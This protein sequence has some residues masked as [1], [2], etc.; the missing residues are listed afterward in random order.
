MV[1][2]ERGRNTQESG[3]G[4]YLLRVV[5]SLLPLLAPGYGQMEVRT[6]Q[7]M[8]R[9]KFLGLIL[10]LLCGLVGVT[11]TLPL[12]LPFDVFPLVFS[13]STSGGRLSTNAPLEA[14]QSIRT[15]KNSY[16]GSKTRIS[17]SCSPIVVRDA[18]MGHM[19]GFQQASLRHSFH[20]SPSFLFHASTFPSSLPHPQCPTRWIRRFT[21]PTARTRF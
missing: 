2:A 19:Q 14:R 15:L 18:R 11:A 1:R 3:R 12:M 21:T 5:A 17:R 4:A 20:Y 13:N 16:L 10:S 9:P 6:T 8:T 7:F